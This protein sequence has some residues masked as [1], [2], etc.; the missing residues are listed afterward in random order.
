MKNW[1][2]G[3]R[4]VA[5]QLPENFSRFKTSRDPTMFRARGY[6]KT[7]ASAATFLL[8]SGAAITAVAQ[9][10][11][12]EQLRPD[13]RRAFAM[14]QD[15]VRTTGRKGGYEPA[16]SNRASAVRPPS[17]SL[18]AAVVRRSG[19]KPAL[20]NSTESLPAIQAGTPLSRILH[21]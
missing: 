21:T 10:L 4:A 9:T 19:L 2:A 3:K 20:A 6:L 17:L 14:R 18:N 12:T 15:V 5:S 11:T 16:R 7:F 8:L 13:N 1:E